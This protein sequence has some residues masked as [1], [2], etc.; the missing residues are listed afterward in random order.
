MLGVEVTR[1]TL[2]PGLEEL[3][4]GGCLHTSSPEDFTL[5][6]GSPLILLKSSKDPLRIASSNKL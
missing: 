4:L 2:L 6:Q 3:P 1:T 5:T